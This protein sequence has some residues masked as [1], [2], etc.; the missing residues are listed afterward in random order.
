[1]AALMGLYALCGMIIVVAGLAAYRYLG[2]VP[3]LGD[4]L[5]LGVARKLR[6]GPGYAVI[7][8]G[9]LIVSVLVMIPIG[10]LCRAVQ[11]SVDTPTY[12]WVHARVSPS[13]L[14]KLNTILTTMGNRDTVDWI[15]LVAL[16]LLAFAYRR[17]WWIP[18]SALLLS[19]A[20]Q[21]KGQAWLA[22]LIDRGQ[23][24]GLNTGTFPSGGVSRA[25]MLY[26]VIL[27]LSLHLLPAIS[28]GWRIGLFT[29]LALLGYAEAYSRLYLS[30]HWISD[31]IGGLMFGVL[32][33]FT[34]SLA[35]RCADTAITSPRLT[36]TGEL[37][38]EMSS[39][40]T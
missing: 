3:A 12:E 1:M 10:I 40:A 18:V 11:S 5:V 4:G 39:T 20:V 13:L 23:P 29:G 24:P 37:H 27:V 32:I 34:V 38:H 26:G 8:I 7:L 36:D 2:Q 21:Y 22:S 9:G 25:L 17:R 15:F 31:I 19:Y 33:I 16:V 14:T 6:A 30:L 35:V 28:R